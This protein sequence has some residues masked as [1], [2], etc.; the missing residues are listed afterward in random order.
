VHDIVQPPHVFT[1]GTLRVPSA[2]GLGVRL[3]PEQFGAARTRYLHMGSYT[4][5]GTPRDDA[6]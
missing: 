5:F 3:D 2:P 6:S 4:S 1:D